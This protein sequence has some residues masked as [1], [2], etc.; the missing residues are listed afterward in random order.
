MTGISACTITYP[1]D[2]IKTKLSINQAVNPDNRLTI[3]GTGRSIYEQRGFFGLYKGLCSTLVGVAPYIAI[4][5]TVFDVQTTLFEISWDDPNAQFFH[6]VFGGIAG[7]T[8]AASTYPIDLLRRKM[9]LSGINGH[10]EYRSMAHAALSIVSKETYRGLYKGM[11]PALLRVGPSMACLF[12]R[13][14][15]IRFYLYH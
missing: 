12:W 6:L 5:M 1:L 14:E 7:I 9:Q 4:R 8:A 3:R 2:L 10:Q 11:A 15:Y 13:N